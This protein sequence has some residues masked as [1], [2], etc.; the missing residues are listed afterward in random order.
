MKDEHI[1]F[2]RKV[3]ILNN[4]GLNFMA[5][6][7]EILKIKIVSFNDGEVYFQVCDVFDTKT[8]KVWSYAKL[9]DKKLYNLSSSSLESLKICLNTYLN[10][11]ISKYQIKQISDNMY[12]AYVTVIKGKKVKYEKYR[13]NVKKEFIQQQ[14]R[15]TRSNGTGYRI[16][17]IYDVAYNTNW[18]YEQINNRGLCSYYNGYY[19][20][21][22][23]LKETLNWFLNGDTE[24]YKFVKGIAYIYD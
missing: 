15:H 17:N 24:K 22:E 14:Q 10:G 11:D 4:R 12:I 9:H 23:E 1:S 18:T 7:N 19:E 16:V 8:N 21:L 6:I 20:T 13:V 5:N 2:Y 3:Q